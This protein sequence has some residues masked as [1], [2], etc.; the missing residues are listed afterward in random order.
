LH[1][2]KGL[3]FPVVF[4]VGVEE[5]L[6]PHRRSLDRDEEVEEERRLCYVG[7]TRA[8]EALYLS[9]AHARLIGGQAALG[10]P[11][12]FLGEIGHANVAFRASPRAATKPRLASV[13]L[14]ERVR[15]PRWDTGTVIQLEG[16]G[17][18]T[19]VTIA[20]DAGARQR[21]ALCHAPLERIAEDPA[22]VLAG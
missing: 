3:E 20:F 2:A 1:T 19:L 17:R 9:Y 15:H 14:G 8:K 11:S 18:D 21:V 13:K 5:G 16:Q 10:H 7:M 12:R 22:N 4:L 6:L